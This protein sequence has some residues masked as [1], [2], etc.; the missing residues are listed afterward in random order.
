MEHCTH[1]VLPNIA[2]HTHS[3]SRSTLL[4]RDCAEESAI[5]SI[6]VPHSQRPYFFSRCST[7]TYASIVMALFMKKSRC[8]AP[9]R[10]PACSR[11]LFFSFR[12][13]RRSSR[14]GSSATRRLAFAKPASVRLLGRKYAEAWLTILSVH[15]H[16]AHKLLQQLFTEAQ[17]QFRLDCLNDLIDE[18]HASDLIVGPDL[19]HYIDLSGEG[20]RIEYGCC[21]LARLLIPHRS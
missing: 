18:T 14:C 4:A 6:L 1:G 5:F 13:D 15:I 11:R 7:S 10:S 16:C 20:I 3:T 19:S 21:M 2:H 12:T 9:M 8:I 17:E